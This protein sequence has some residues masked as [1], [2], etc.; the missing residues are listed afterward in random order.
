MGNAKM[1]KFKS[2]E[3]EREYWLTHSTA[4]VWDVAQEVEEPIVDARP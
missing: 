4:E 3:E 2:E 1:P